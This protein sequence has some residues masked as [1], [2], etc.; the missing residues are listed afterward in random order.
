MTERDGKQDRTQEAKRPQPAGQHAPAEPK[1]LDEA[2][3]CGPDCYRE[4]SDG[5]G[6]KVR[7]LL[8]QGKNGGR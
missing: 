4:M 3:D 6:A 8:E 7:E 2:A 1:P 5:A